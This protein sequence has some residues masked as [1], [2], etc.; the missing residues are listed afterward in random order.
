LVLY[1]AHGHHA[2]VLLQLGRHAELV[3]GGRH[4][5]R[6]VR[7]EVLHLLLELLIL[8]VDLLVLA[9]VLGTVNPL[10]LFPLDI[11]LNLVAKGE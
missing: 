11:L 10:L 9:A 6:V 1:L 2:V 8:S 7:L 5:D 3:G 4:S